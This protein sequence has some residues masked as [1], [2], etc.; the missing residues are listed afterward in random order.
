MTLRNANMPAHGRFIVAR[1][2]YQPDITNV[3][4][5]ICFL[6]RFKTMPAVTICHTVSCRAF[7]RIPA[8][9]MIP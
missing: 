3:C 5:C 7:G 4:L 8:W 1:L 2:Q 6:P 9:S